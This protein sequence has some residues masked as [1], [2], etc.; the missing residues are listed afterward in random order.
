[1]SDADIER[2]RRHR[3][4]ARDRPLRQRPGGAPRRSVAAAGATAARSTARRVI[5]GNDAPSGTGV[6]PLGILRVM[7]HL[8][9]LGG[10]AP[11]VAVAM[12]TGNT[13]RVH[14]LDV[15]VLAPGRA[16]DLV[17]VD[18]PIGSVGDDGARGAARRRPAGHLD[19]A[20]RRRGHDRPEPEH[21]AGGAR[22]RDRRRRRGPA[23]GGH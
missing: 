12:A 20:H 3:H 19:G 21:A 8:A 10:V 14:G 11:E 17:L 9:S 13:A 1:M 15:G 16:A 18:A 7:A 23:A 5:I 6:V 2:R 22:R 4:G